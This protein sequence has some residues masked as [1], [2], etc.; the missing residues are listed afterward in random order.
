MKICYVVE[1]SKKGQSFWHRIG[2]AFENDDG[3]LDVKL[4]AFPV[5]GE[6]VIREYVPRGG[7]APSSGGGG[8]SGMPA[9]YEPVGGAGVAPGDDDDDIPF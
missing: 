8:G 7:G 4:Q 5:N 9:G 2:V 3:S 1:K 6:M